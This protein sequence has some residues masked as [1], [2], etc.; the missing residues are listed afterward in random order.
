MTAP[1][2]VSL[3]RSTFL[4]GG[5]AASLLLA[6]CGGEE[7]SASPGADESGRN[8][9]LPAAEGTTTYPLE[10]ESGFGTTDLEARPE[11][12]GVISPSTVDSDTLLALGIA[13][14]Y[15][16]D[17]VELEPWAEVET[18]AG[19]ETFWAAE[20][21]ALPSAEE[22]LAASPDLIV[23]LQAPEAFG[24]EDFDR[25]SSIAPLLLPDPDARPS[26]EDIAARLGEVLDL[27]EASTTLVD[28]IHSEL[29]AVAGRNPGFA[30]LSA[31]HVH[32]Y[33]QEHGAAYF[34]FPGSDSAAL[35][36]RFGFVLP[37]QAE[38]FT[39]EN[40]QIS[41]EL[42]SE[43]DADLLLVTSNPSPEGAEWFTGSELFRSV[44]AVEDGRWALYEPD[45][46]EQF[47]AFAWAIRMQSPLSL[48]WAAGTL[49]D[50]A[51]EALG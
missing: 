37:A 22:V 50:L 32:V 44:P 42:V 49:E 12:I 28:D 46:E 41:D 21:G 38:Q 4:L 27:T 30:G 48:P 31:A 47:A 23:A 40:Y 29:D 6:G 9:A 17:T 39:A 45:P 26:W 43:I 16:P 1:R 14:V 18:L 33:S 25:F 15:A 2:R 51:T 5:V 20:A 35:L 24:Q 7:D 13:P 19:V 34:S 36:E 8:A 10:L 11:R 3:T